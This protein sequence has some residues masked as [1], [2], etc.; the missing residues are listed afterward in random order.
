MALADQLVAY[1]NMAQ[2]PALFKVWDQSGNGN[3]LTGFNSPVLVDGK[4][5][6]AIQFNGT[7]QFLSI[8]SNS[9]FSHQGGE[10]SAFIWFKLLS[11]ANQQL[12]TTTTE[13][14][15][16]TVLSG[17]NYYVSIAV[18]DETLVITDVP[19]EVD[20]WYFLACGWYGVEHAATRGTYAWGSLNLSPRV[21]ELQ[22]ALTPAPEVFSVAGT[23]AIGWTHV[24][25]DDI[26]IFRRFVT[27]EETRALYN[28]GKGL[29][30]E[31][32]GTV[33]PCRTIDCCD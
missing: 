24:V 1:W 9:G 17:G 16:G 19:L 32:W 4:L 21:R 20:K 28:K 2:N 3:H 18:E 7:N 5:G 13:W 22:S 10:F 8:A 29:P 31:E 14:G 12:I 15:V 33:T 27:A 6:K 23:A 11:L 26:T 25:I 30:F